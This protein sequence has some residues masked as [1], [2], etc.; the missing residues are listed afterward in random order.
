MGS[1][2]P[3]TLGR[4]RAV[5]SRKTKADCPSL[6]SRSNMRTALLIQKIEVST[7]AKNPNMT[8]NC[9]SMY[10]SNLVTLIPP[11]T[12]YLVA[13]Y[14]KTTEGK[15][16]NG[17]ISGR[18]VREMGPSAMNRAISRNPVRNPVRNRVRNPVRHL[19]KVPTHPAGG[20]SPDARGSGQSGPCALPLGL[21]PKPDPETRRARHDHPRRRFLHGSCP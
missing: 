1:T 11:E 2:P 9:D 18:L 20:R 7:R 3:M 21:T 8:S 6:I 13:S 19:V 5:N 4:V 14:R 10:L 16:V 17:R 12:L 15:T